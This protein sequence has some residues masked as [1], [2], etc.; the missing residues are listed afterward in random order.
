[1]N[2]TE[3]YWDNRYKKSDIGWDIGEISTPLKNY[4]DQL[5]NKETRILI[6]GGGNS[7]EAEYLHNNNFKNIYVV[8]VSKTAL[9]NFSTRVPSFPKEHLLHSNFF[10]LDIKFDLIIEQTFFCAINP[11]LRSKYVLKAY[12]LLNTNGKVAGLLFNLPLNDNEPPFG[13]SKE[14]YLTYFTPYFKIKTME[15]AYNSIKP[16]AGK[17]LFYIITKKEK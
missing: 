4:F 12:N 1:M 8:D 17:E 10:D 9:N 3:D 5:K 13:G 11:N 6:P 7:Y 16:R 2:L 15:E 14:E